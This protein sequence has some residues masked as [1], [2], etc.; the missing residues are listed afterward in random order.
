MGLVCVDNLMMPCSPFVDF[1]CCAGFLC[2]NMST[3]CL[4]R[5]YL[6]RG[7]LS[8]YLVLLPVTSFVCCNLM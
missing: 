5:F 1:L 3:C 8:P 4:N 7:L 2:T 6:P